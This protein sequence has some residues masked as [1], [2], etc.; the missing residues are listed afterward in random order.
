M[1]VV[2][3]YPGLKALDAFVP[4]PQLTITVLS[5]KT[6]DNSSTS[7]HIN[8]NCYT[9]A[10]IHDTTITCSL[11]SFVFIETKKKLYNPWA[12]TYPIIFFS[13]L[14]NAFTKTL[15]KVKS[16]MVDNLRKTQSLNENMFNVFRC[17]L[18][19]VVNSVKEMIKL[20]FNFM[21]KFEKLMS[22]LG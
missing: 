19:E 16:L 13:N 17:F 7:K 2:V 8:L 12:H 3:G 10:K 1:Y 5:D 21:S 4:T 15:F 14:K 22:I 20:L 11:M 6:I 9:Q 18:N